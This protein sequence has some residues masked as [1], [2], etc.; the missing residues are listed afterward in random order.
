MALRD[1]PDAQSGWRREPAASSSV[2]SRGP[3]RGPALIQIAALLI[4]LAGIAATGVWMFRSNAGLPSVL[5]R[6]L[7]TFANKSPAPPVSPAPTAEP[8][9]APAQPKATRRRVRSVP[10]P[11]PL[12]D[13]PPAEIKPSQTSASASPGV[14]TPPAPRGEAARDI[15][16]AE[17]AGLYSASDADV[18]PP[19]PI[20]L[21]SFGALAAGVGP[22]E[23][24]T[25]DLVVNER[26]NVV[27]AKINRAPRTVGESMLFAMG[28][29]SIKSWQFRP[30]LK[31]GNPVRYRQSISVGRK[32]TRLPPP[33]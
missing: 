11:P 22:D 3:A 23:V 10:S 27:L 28:L 14:P 13:A 26:G 32:A 18:T 9:K 33:D 24:V 1:Q 15:A 30:A 4:V 17:P 31:D 12:N 16:P 8:A 7:P 21:P 19:E 20:S 25:F 2:G 29:Q 5:Q 6:V